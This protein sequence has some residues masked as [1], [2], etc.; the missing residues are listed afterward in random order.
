MKITEALHGNLRR[1][2][3]HHS[4]NRSL[5]PRSRGDD[6][7]PP[8]NLRPRTNKYPDQICIMLPLLFFTFCPLSRVRSIFKVSMLP[9]L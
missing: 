4:L 8:R 3:D 1:N 7:N 2:T 6:K 9:L 5:T